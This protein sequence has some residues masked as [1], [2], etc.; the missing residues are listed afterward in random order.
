MLQ[1]VGVGATKVDEMNPCRTF[2]TEQERV[3]E[4]GR[5]LCVAPRT[6]PLCNPLTTTTPRPPIY[7]RFLHSH[8]FRRTE[9]TVQPRFLI[10]SYRDT[11]HHQHPLS[12]LTGIAAT[13]ID[14]LQ[15]RVL[16]ATARPGPS[17]DTHDGPTSSQATLSPPGPPPTSSLTALYVDASSEARREQNSF[18]EY[19]NDCC[20]DPRKL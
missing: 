15:E 18:L 20:C 12:Q 11:R 9:S 8:S 17:I 13:I 3:L 1:F 6:M 19:V 10:S 5:P 14:I 7:P 4:P 2:L 16:P